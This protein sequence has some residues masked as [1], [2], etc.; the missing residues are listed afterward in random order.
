[1]PFNAYEQIEILPDVDLRTK[2]SENLFVGVLYYMELMGVIMERELSSFRTKNIE[3]I[4][5]KI[6][7]RK[8]TVPIRDIYGIRIITEDSRREWIKDILQKAYPLTPDI[9][10]DGKPSVREYANPTIREFFREKHSPYTSP[11]YSALHV[12]V[13]FKREGSHLLDIAEIQIMNKRELK[14]YNDTREEYLQK[15]SLT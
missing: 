11:L 3:R 13:V 6:K 1:M 12:N 15:R 4:Q 5:E 7:R 2:I 14:I 9:F 8:S 10:P